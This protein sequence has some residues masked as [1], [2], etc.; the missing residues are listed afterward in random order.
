ME[1]DKGV[2]CASV[3]VDLVFIWWKWAGV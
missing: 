3:A 1:H 2:S